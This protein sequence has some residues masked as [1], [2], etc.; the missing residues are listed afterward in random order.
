MP[1]SSRSILV[2]SSG[3]VN[4]SDSPL[5]LSSFSLNIS[6]DLMHQI[7]LV[8]LSSELFLKKCGY[9]ALELR[10]HSG[11]GGRFFICL[12]L[13]EK[14]LYPVVKFISKDHRSHVSVAFRE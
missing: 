2:K 11:C 14:V 7:Y 6:K 10:I 5:D 9:L 12:D 1:I 8:L 3:A 4:F 13:F